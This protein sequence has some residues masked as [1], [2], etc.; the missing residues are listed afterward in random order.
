MKHTTDGC[1]QFN[2]TCIALGNFDG[3]HRGHRAVL[4]TLVRVAAERGLTSVLLSFDC[5]EAQTGPKRLTSETEKLL[6]LENSDLAAMV[7]CKMD[8]SDFSQ[9]LKALARFG[10]KA[11][12][13]GKND[14]RLALLQQHAD[15]AGFELITCGVV[16]QDGAVLTTARAAALLQACDFTGLAE[17]LGHQYCIYGEVLC[18][19]QLGRTVGMPTANI[20][21][22]SNKFLP[23]DGVYGT[24]TVCGGVPYMGLANIGRRPTVDRFDYITVEDYLLDF[25]QD[26]YGQ[27]IRMDVHAHIRGVEK[28][29]SLAEVKKQVELDVQAVRSALEEKMQ[30]FYTGKVSEG[31][32]A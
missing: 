20:S 27:F 4:D 17:L 24:I 8:G 5:D 14:R 19:K 6:F 2:N 1:A 7:S 10:A 11:V 26:I 22:M 21:F 15:A 31:R 29:N 3:M 30:K 9:I 25:S 13:V 18:G 16:E 23:P 32:E 28:F 12:V